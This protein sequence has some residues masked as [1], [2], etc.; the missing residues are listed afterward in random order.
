[1]KIDLTGTDL[2]NK[3]LQET[4]IERSERDWLVVRRNAETFEAFGGT[5]NLNEMIDNFLMWA[6]EPDL[7]DRA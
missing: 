6:D 7:G 1:M 2:Q 5:A 4:R 3:P